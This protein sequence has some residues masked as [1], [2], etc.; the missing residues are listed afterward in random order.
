M[1]EIDKLNTNEKPRNNIVPNNLNK[2]DIL[3]ASPV[4]IKKTTI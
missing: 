1:K 3:N 2:S 4:K